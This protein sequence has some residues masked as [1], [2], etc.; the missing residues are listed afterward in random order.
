MGYA[1]AKNN[2]YSTLAAGIS[3]VA[4]TITVAAGTGSR[5]PTISSGNYFYATLFNTAN[6]L[7]VVKVIGTA[8]DNFTVVRG[9]D[10]TTAKTYLAN[11]RIELRPTAALFNDKMPISGGAFTGGVAVPA[12]A[13]GTQVPQIQEVVKKS[14]DTMTGALTLTELRG[15]GGVVDVPAGHRISGADT[16]SLV[17]PGMIVQFATLRV[18]T[19]VAYAVTTSSGSG[20]TA[21]DRVILDELDIAFTPKFANSKVL[22]QY[23]ISGEPSSHDAVW[24]LLRD[25]TVIGRNANYSNRRSGL[26][27]MVYDS[28]QNSTPTPQA[29]SYVDTPGST[30]TVTYHLAMQPSSDGVNTRTYYLNRTVGGFPG[31]EREV[32]ISQVHIMEIAQ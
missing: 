1:L 14:G 2:A 22:I 30:A 6:D 8:G 18:D 20:A 16:G 28:D 26:V 32:G 25:T 29:F 15:D 27:P 5:F 4:T 9:Q 24:V 3:D 21:S 10:G 17:A 12:G 11:D 19:I 7:E 31:N 23:V 13:T